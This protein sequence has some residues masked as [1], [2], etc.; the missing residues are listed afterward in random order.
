MAV[1]VCM[2]L[3]RI[4]SLYNRTQFETGFINQDFDWNVMSEKDICTLWILS[5]SFKEIRLSLETNKIL[6]EKQ[7]GTLLIY[8]VYGSLYW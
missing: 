8:M 1:I 5:K 2:N 6:L 7:P 4:W 3:I